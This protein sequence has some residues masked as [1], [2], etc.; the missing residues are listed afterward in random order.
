[1]ANQLLRLSIKT[2]QKDQ[3]ID[4]TSKIQDLV[5]KANIKSGVVLIYVPHTTAAI[6]VNENADPDV[7]IDV[8]KAMNDTFPNMKEYRHLEGNSPAHIKTSLFGVEK[9]II[10][11]D[12]KL[13]LGTWQ[14]IYLC[15]FDGPRVRNVFVKIMPD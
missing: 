4:I 10:I 7:V 6:T 1:M 2:N 3:F 5:S 13:V 12:N 11:D 8:I 14:G 9:T 15:E